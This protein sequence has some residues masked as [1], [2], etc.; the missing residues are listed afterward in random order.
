MRSPRLYLS[1]MLAAIKAIEDFTFGMDR[2]IFLDDEKTKSAVVRQFEII[3]EAA[4]SVP[5]EIKSLAPELHWR[6]IAG[7][8]DR[9]V[10]AYFRVDY[11]LVWDTM[12]SELPLLENQLTVLIEKLKKDH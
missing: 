10:H 2:E 1:E 9:L 7:M 4:K 3:G 12:Q 11:D 6:G 8:R 5:D